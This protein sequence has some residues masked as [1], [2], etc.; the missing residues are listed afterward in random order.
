MKTP[1]T[2]RDRLIHFTVDALKRLPAPETGRAYYTDDGD[3][4][5]SLQVTAG[6]AKTF[7]IQA[8][9]NGVPRRMMLGRF[10]TVK[11]DAARKKAATLRVEIAAGADPYERT[12][13]ARRGM[14]VAE[15]FDEYMARHAEPHLSA[16]TVRQ[17]RDLWRMHVA[18]CLGTMRLPAVTRRDV[19][20]LHLDLGK[21][22]GHRT[23]NLA[24][25][26]V[27]AMFNRAIA[28][29]LFDGRN[30]GDRIRK[31]PEPPRERFLRADEMPR[32]LDVLEK[33]ALED[34]NTLWRDLILMHLLTGARRSNLLRMRWADIDANAA[35]WTIGREEMKARRTLVLPLVP[36]A[37]RILEGRRLA[38]PGDCPWVFPSPR[39]S[40]AA[41][42]ELQP[43]AD[44]KSR[45]N[46]IRREA[47]IDDVRL[48]DLRR[49]L[50]SWL[51]A[52]NANVAIISKSLGHS[53]LS[54]TAVYMRLD[55]SPVRLAM[56]QVTTAMLQVG[57]PITA[58]AEGND[59]D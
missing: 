45:W 32:L 54:S 27:R 43:L 59:H 20:T 39:S 58:A 57:S 7:F 52:S 18:P 8:R 5:L 25:G 47:G 9:V 37:M 2:D 44:P 48:H 33:H 10:P 53:N 23:A 1:G 40:P 51:A 30:P 13:P 55:V 38:V 29:E 14:T 28:W 12:R 11:I 35:T 15:L 4:R 19:E 6:G 42:P 16:K 21:R 50:G 34:G 17:Y 31:F 22:V 26:L 41:G 46:R 24:A 3:E 36:A 56:E 49:T